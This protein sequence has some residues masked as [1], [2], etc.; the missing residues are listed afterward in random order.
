MRE[1]WQ[2][3]RREKTQQKP[4]PSLLDATFTHSWH[5]ILKQNGI[6]ASNILSVLVIR[7]EKGR[8]CLS[9]QLTDK[10]VRKDV[11]IY[12]S[13]CSADDVRTDLRVLDCVIK[14]EF[15]RT[16]C[17][18]DFPSWNFYGFTTEHPAPMRF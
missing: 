13:E 11:W 15:E 9:F 7:T 14:G 18:R 12:P 8:I 1:T 5:S 2:R 16:G 4:K 10:S 6:K 17:V 3:L